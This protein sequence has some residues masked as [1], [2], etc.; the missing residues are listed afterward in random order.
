MFEEVGTFVWGD[1]LKECADLFPESWKSA[2][3]GFAKQ[4]LELREHHFDRIEIG[5]IGWEIEQS[6]AGRFDRLPHACNLVRRQIVHDDDISC[7]QGRNKTCA[8]I[9]QEHIPVHR[10][11]DDKGRDD[12]ITAQARHEGHDFPMAMGNLGK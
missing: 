12:A 6:C 7:T 11:V 3:R 8:E 10:T 1:C 5:G 4:S 9:G 2:F